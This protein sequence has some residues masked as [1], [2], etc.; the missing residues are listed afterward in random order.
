M[1]VSCNHPTE[2]RTEVKHVQG[3]LNDIYWK[4]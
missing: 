3:D 4:K 2:A 1:T